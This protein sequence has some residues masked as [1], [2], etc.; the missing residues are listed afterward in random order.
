MRLDQQME[1]ASAQQSNDI[2]RQGDDLGAGW[3]SLI[4][5][6]PISPYSNL[7]D[8]ICTTSLA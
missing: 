1:M 4:H 7:F 2:F 6:K 3:G 5:E 8:A